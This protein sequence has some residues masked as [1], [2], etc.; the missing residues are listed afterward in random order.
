MKP[1]LFFFLIAF[2]FMTACDKTT[3]QGKYDQIK[4]VIIAPE[5]SKKLSDFSFD[6]FKKL[7][8]DAQINET[9]NI[10]VSPLSLHMALA[11]L[12]NGTDNTTK[13][14]LLTALRAND[15]TI[16]ELNELHK[17]LMA[18][19][20]EA[21]RRVILK[22]ANAIFYRNS[23]SVN[24]TFLTVTND[25]YAAV[26][27]GLPFIAS[28][29]AI[30]NKWAY[31]NTNGKIPKVLDKINPDDVMFLLNALYFKGDWR[32]KFDTK[33]TTDEA[34]LSENG[35]RRTV[36]M[37][38]AEDTLLLYS[39]SR[40]FSAITKSYGNSQFSATFILPQDGK[41]IADVMHNMNTD[42]WQEI[43]KK[44][45]ITKV[46]FGLP[47][48]TLS[49]SYR[50][51]NTLQRMGVKQMFTDAA[52]LSK[53]S[54]SRTKV[55]FVK[56]DTYVGVD[57]VGTEAAAVTTIGI[58]FTSAPQIVT[59]KCDKPFGIIISERTSGVILFMGKVMNP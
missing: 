54:E 34:F 30:V 46:Q 23:F 6:F 44:A 47:R 38:N 55:S 12:T 39:G 3:P 57:E 58:E 36:K 50:L 27:K 10:F 1:I 48:F 26:A 15:M 49:G 42:I 37:M 29:A 40:D 5:A 45:R 24:K 2:T 41:K 56:Q 8:I 52:D 21:D 22:L 25:F 20:P 17:K 19:L 7:Q 33:N 43:T 51:N 53:L 59:F 16:G 11:M 35:T 28:D 13:T 32:S 14:E 31:D 4:P 9:D 18:Q